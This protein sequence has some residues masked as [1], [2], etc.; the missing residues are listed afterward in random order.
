[1]PLVVSP[2]TPFLE[3]CVNELPLP[4]PQVLHKGEGSLLDWSALLRV[5]VNTPMGSSSQSGLC[6]VIAN[7]V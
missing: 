4:C 6:P 1:M 7:T 3:A 2:I 5:T